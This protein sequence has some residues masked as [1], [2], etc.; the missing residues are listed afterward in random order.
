[1]EIPLPQFGVCAAEALLKLIDEEKLE[2]QEVRVM[3]K[4]IER[5]SVK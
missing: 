1:M 5:A 4:L 3:C 2:G